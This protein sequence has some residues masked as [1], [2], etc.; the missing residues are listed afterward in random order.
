ME[1]DRGRRQRVVA[2]VV[3]I[4]FFVGAVWLVA[5]GGRLTSRT[6]ERTPSPSEPPF[7][8]EAPAPIRAGAAGSTRVGFVGLPP[9][10]ATPSEP[11][12]GEIVLEY[13]GRRFATWYQVVVYADGR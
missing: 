8:S 9:V 1:P 5:T 7:P 4:A 6:P 11:R 10:G 13:Q 12:T 2:G 3:G